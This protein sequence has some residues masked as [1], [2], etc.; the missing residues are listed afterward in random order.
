MLKLETTL[1][2]ILSDSLINTNCLGKE[3]VLTVA[4]NKIC[5]SHILYSE[6]KLGDFTNVGMPAENM[7][8]GQIC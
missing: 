5:C 7:T 8:E 6:G 3:K 2:I 4:N 1:Q